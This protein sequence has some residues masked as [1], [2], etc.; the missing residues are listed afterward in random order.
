M[1]NG[2]VP[3]GCGSS[4]ALAYFIVYQ[5]VVGQIFLNLFIAIV[6]DTYLI[7]KEANARCIKDLEIENFQEIWKEY[8][9]YA[10]G[11]IELNQLDP[12]IL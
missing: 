6:V 5:I 9:K 8:D 7:R 2:G 10:T 1:L 3:N 4:F 12:F 11:M